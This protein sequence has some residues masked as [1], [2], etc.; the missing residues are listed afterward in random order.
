MGKIPFARN[1]NFILKM[2]SKQ[3]TC[4]L[5]GSYTKDLDLI[6]QI[7]DIFKLAGVTILC[8]SSFQTISNSD[9]VRFVD[10][11][12][13][14]E[15]IEARLLNI[16]HANR[17]NP[18]F[19]AYFVNR[20]GYLGASAS[21]ELSQVRSL[22]ANYFLLQQPKTIPIKVEGFRIVRPYSIATE[23]LSQMRT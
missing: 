1:S 9:F 2:N 11:E 12:G 22:G 7:A 8:P 18:D 14:P 5:H 6:E 13:S 21:Y 15:E 19:F 3:I 17:S 16:I 23:L 4:T 10:D 20:Q